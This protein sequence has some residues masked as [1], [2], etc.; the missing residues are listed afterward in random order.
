MN[1][2]S[3][4]ITVRA[5][6]RQHEKIQEFIDRVIVSSR[7]QVLIEATIVEVTLGD[8]YQQGIE[9]TKLITGATGVGLSLTPAS[10]NSNVGNALTPF[11]LSTRTSSELRD[12]QHRQH[13][14][15]LRHR[16]GSLQPAPVGDEQPDGPAQ[17]GRELRLFQR[18]GRYRNRPPT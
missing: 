8:G 17:G 5:T 7:R 15:G 6:A 16:Q 2:E 14:A 13:P 18:Q 3:G 1:P 11:T 10:V 12:Q 4:V 9:W